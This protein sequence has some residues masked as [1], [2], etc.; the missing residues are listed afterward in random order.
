[1]GVQFRFVARIV[2]I[3]LPLATTAARLHG[4]HVDAPDL[5]TQ[6]VNRCLNLIKIA[7]SKRGDERGMKRKECRAYGDGELSDACGTEEERPESAEEPIAPR[8]A[9]RPGSSARIGN[10]R[11]TGDAA[12]VLPVEPLLHVHAT[13]GL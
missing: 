9:G 8:R 13:Q 5:A 4:H 12:W 11:L 7:A 3:L 2:L 10:S 6:E 1:M